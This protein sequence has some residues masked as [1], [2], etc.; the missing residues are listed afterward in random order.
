MDN[1]GGSGS[2]IG[3]WWMM[4]TMKMMTQLR[5]QLTTM[6]VPPPSLL[7]SLLADALAS[8]YFPALSVAFGLPLLTSSR[9]NTVMTVDAPSFSNRLP[10]GGHIQHHCR[11]GSN[12]DDVG[13][14]INGREVGRRGA[15][16]YCHCHHQGNDEMTPTTMMMISMMMTTM[17]MTMMMVH[18]RPGFLPLLGGEGAC[19]LAGNVGNMSPTGRFVADLVPTCMSGPT[20]NSK[21]AEPTQNFVSVTP[22]LIYTYTYLCT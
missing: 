20:H 1:D 2:S 9:S 17:T 7:P 6:V 19:A 22:L 21:I 14:D 4:T 3:Q 5:W 11:D 12:R 18:C 16:Q 10:R 13:I 8:L 15:D